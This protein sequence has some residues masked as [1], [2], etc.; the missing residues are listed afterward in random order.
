M[1]SS[2]TA[3]R[4]A[5]VDGM[6]VCPCLPQSAINITAAN[7]KLIEKELQTNLSGYNLSSF[8]VGCRLH[9]IDLPVC[10]DFNEV[11][12]PDRSGCPKTWCGR[13]W[14]YV[15]SNNC[16]AEHNPSQVVPGIHFSYGTCYEIN[17]FVGEQRLEAIENSTFRVHILEGNTGWTTA[18]SKKNGTDGHEIEDWVGPLADFVR[19]AAKNRA[20]TLVN[21]FTPSERMIA[22]AV[23][24]FGSQSASNLCIFATKLGLVDFCVGGFTITDSR[25]TEVD[26]LHLQTQDLILVVEA[27]STN[28]FAQNASGIFR[29]FHVEVWVFILF[30]VMPVFALILFYHE[31]K[32]QGSQYPTEESFIVVN[33]ETQTESMERIRIPILQHLWRSFFANILGLFEGTFGQSVVTSGGKLHILAINFFIFLFGAIYT[34]N[35]AA[36]LTTT[37]AAT[38]VASFND[39]LS[40]GYRFCVTRQRYNLVLSHFPFVPP[41]AFVVDPNDGLPGFSNA[42]GGSNASQVVFDRISVVNANLEDTNNVPHL[43]QRYCHAGL[44]L[45]DEL[46]LQHSKLNLCGL[47]SVGPA[48]VPDTHG[49]PVFSAK[50]VPIIAWLLQEKNTGLLGNILSNAQ[51]TSQC[52]VLAQPATALDI[53]Q[54]TGVWIVCFGLCLLGVLHTVIVTPIYLHMKRRNPKSRNIDHI[55]KYDQHGVYI[56]TYDDTEENADI[57]GGDDEVATNQKGFEG[58]DNTMDISNSTVGIV[59][60]GALGTD[61]EASYGSEL[62]ERNNEVPEAAAMHGDVKEKGEEEMESPGPLPVSDTTLDVQFQRNRNI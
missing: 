62:Y 23:E 33:P 46:L 8:G 11:T 52:G 19:L 6:D 43:Q 2:L 45:S 41:T 58:G 55:Y 36:I 50:S 16:R 15:D 27:Q 42:L 12:C 54:L 22:N 49:F 30:F 51:P 7:V 5:Y 32:A 21:N 1:C 60:L 28:S 17:R 24:H 18:L 39:A 10:S 29:P 34:A 4:S 31:Y 57:K 48:V 9:D 14:C 47:V 40:N 35:L 61:N 26:W 13:S 38:P 3:I 37:I 44:T 53:S 25:A 56:R 20:I 59:R